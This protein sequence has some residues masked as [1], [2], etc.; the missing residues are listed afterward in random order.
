MR[1]LVS[2][3]L[4][5]A[6]VG[7]AKSDARP[8]KTV[9][10]APDVGAQVVKQPT[11]AELRKKAKEHFVNQQPSGPLLFYLHD[12]DDHVLDGIL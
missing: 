4:L 6:V 10:R 12:E 2:I 8:A 11:R 7:C 5:A 1:T 9:E 3:L